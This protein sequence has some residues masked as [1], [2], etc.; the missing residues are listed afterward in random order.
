MTGKVIKLAQIKK[1]SREW[2]NSNISRKY[3]LIED[4]Q[5]PA[6]SYVTPSPFGRFA[7]KLFVKCHLTHFPLMTADSFCKSNEL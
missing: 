5:G 7:T 6:D 1:L 4:M 2:T 3:L